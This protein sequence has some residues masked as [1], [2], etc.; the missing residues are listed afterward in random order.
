MMWHLGDLKEYALLVDS[1]L[2]ENVTI[3]SESEEYKK[4]NVLRI[5]MTEEI[6]SLKEI[7]S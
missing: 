3:L 5:E 6:T 2:K 1:I 7:T 4:M